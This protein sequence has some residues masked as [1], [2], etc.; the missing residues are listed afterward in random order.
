MPDVRELNSTPPN[1]T[2]LDRVATTVASVGRAMA[3]TRNAIRFGVFLTLIAGLPSLGQA[4]S[5]WHFDRVR[6]KSGAELCGLIQRESERQTEF[7]CIR[8]HPGRPTVCMPTT[9][10]NREIDQ[11]VR[12]EPAQRQIL[13]QRI[14]KLKGDAEQQQERLRQIHLVPIDWRGRPSG[15][16]RYQSDYFT[17]SSDASDEI[18]RRA[19]V[20]LEQ[21]YA[22]FG[23]FLPA[24]VNN[25]PPTSIQIFRSRDDYRQ[26]LKE[27]NRGF[28]NSAFF[29][30]SASRIVCACDLDRFAGELAHVRKQHQQFREDLARQEAALAKLYKGKELARHLQQIRETLPKLA[31]ADKL[32]EAGFDQA[33]KRFFATL[34][35]EAMH[36]YVAAFVY[37]P[38]GAELPLWLNEGLAQNFET[39]M[40]E[41]GELRFDHADLRRLTKVK[42][43]LRKKSLPSMLELLR[44]GPQQ[45]QPVHPIDCDDTNAIYLA[46]WGLARYVTMER[47]YL[48]TP[49]FVRYLAELREGREPV[50]AFIALLDGD[51][52]AF[53]D[54]FH[55]YLLRLQ[56][57]GS[58][59]DIA[60]KVAP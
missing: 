11:V 23:R 51:L 14:E 49:S 58:Q 59:R 15:G 57:D 9:L 28:V 46:A 45:F 36:A 3:V 26:L 54:E 17:L 43:L 40:I 32:N 30:P 8:R 4:E 44:S 35:H 38:G 12:L 22:A 19:A 48:G 33:S 20:R 10:A 21:I 13:T 47:G 37:P 34:Y 42:E 53:E 2:V 55:R 31:Q 56:P 16:W 24:R 50:A 60:L 18:V 5:E 7:L 27:E 41:A 29:D 52:Q 6:L 39:A 1:A 25:V